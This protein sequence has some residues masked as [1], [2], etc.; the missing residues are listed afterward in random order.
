M[1][2]SNPELPPESLIKQICYPSLFQVT[3][4]AVMHGHKYEAVAIAANE[5]HMKQSHKKTANCS[6]KRM[7]LFGISSIFLS[8]H[9]YCLHCPQFKK[10]KVKQKEKQTKETITKVEQSVIT[11][12]KVCA[13]QARPQTSERLLEGHS[14]NYRDGHFF[15]LNCLGYLHM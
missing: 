15:H 12:D 5:I 1:F 2:H 3:T 9:W 7:P 13:C 6:N 10:G 14:V 4:K 11:L 8:N